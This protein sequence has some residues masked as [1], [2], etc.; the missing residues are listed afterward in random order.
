MRDAA[1]RRPGSQRESGSSLIETLVAIALLGGVVVSLA[2]LLSM[3][4][5]GNVAARAS[6]RAVIL[7]EQ[8]ME[9]LKALAWAFDSE[10]ARVSDTT[11]NVA[12]FAAIGGCAGAQAGAGAGLTPSA[13][14][15]LLAN[16]DGYVDYVDAQGCGLGGGQSPPAGTAYIRRWSVAPAEGA[17]D[18]LVFHVLVTADG[19]RTAADQA[20]NTRRPGDAW[21]I[22]M[23]SR[24]A[25]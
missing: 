4:T 1:P 12:A 10:G 7:A 14:G 22:G 19:V 21:L 8:K 13:P 15:A 25:P 9:Q 11:S 2:E 16:Q 18:T 24:R 23:K 3:A 20:S 6:T 17:A 5:R